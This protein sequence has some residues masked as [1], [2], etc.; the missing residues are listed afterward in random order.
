M[1]NR[2]D[3]ALEAALKNPELT[4]EDRKDLKDMHDDAIVWQCIRRGYFTYGKT[5]DQLVPTLRMFLEG[6]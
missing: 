4:D 6:P 3:L 2:Y 1:A 5:V